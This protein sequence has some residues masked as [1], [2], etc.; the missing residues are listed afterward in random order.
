MSDQERLEEYLEDECITISV[1]E[2]DDEG[3]TNRDE[4]VDRFQGC[5]D[6]GAQFSEEL[7]YEYHHDES[8]QTPSWVL[9]H[10]DWSSV[11]ECELRHDFVQV[12]DYIFNRY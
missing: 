3:I 11:W 5:Y 1:D 9:N 7:F 4:F 12:D 8:K 6:S 10:V 2:L